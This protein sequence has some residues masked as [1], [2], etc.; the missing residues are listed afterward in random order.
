MAYPDHNPDVPV[1][2]GSL[3]YV[4]YT[5]GSTGRPK[6]VA[7]EHRALVN[8]IATLPEVLGETVDSPALVTASV[9]FDPFIEQLMLGL[10]YGRPVV[11][12][13]DELSDPARFWE[14][15]RRHGV[16]RADL[17]PS[18]AGRL[19][20]HYPT[21]G[22][23]LAQVLLGG[24]GRLFFSG[25]AD[26]RKS[27]GYSYR[28]FLRPTEAVIDCIAGFLEPEQTDSVPIGKPMPN[29]RAYILDAHGQP[30]P[31]GVPGELCIG[32][33]ALARGYLNRPELTAEAFIPNPF[34]E[35][36]LYKTGDLARWLEDGSIEY[37]GTHR[38][39]GQD[40][41]LPY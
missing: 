28:Q 9:N 35:G 5:S 41:R 15:I 29:Y 40:P 4:I 32:G 36:R 24:R 26:P 11:L 14:T 37:L 33:E 30:V 17:V 19:F 6:G 7:V 21:E 2:P 1:A 25:A 22:T 34:A 12:L 3:A 18:I 20:E 10:A 27:P 38:R 16:R 39:A 31:I 8:K 23:P 13:D